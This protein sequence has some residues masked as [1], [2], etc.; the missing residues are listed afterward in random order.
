MPVQGAE[1]D[2]PAQ[3]AVSTSEIRKGY[4]VNL[5]HGGMQPWH[6]GGAEWRKSSYSNPSGNC[7]ETASLSSGRVA[8]RDSKCPG[9]PVLVFTG[10]AWTAFLSS[11]RAACLEM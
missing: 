11:L 4:A 2:K 1:G 7:V 6:S 9:G 8:V 3:M 5:A 10:T